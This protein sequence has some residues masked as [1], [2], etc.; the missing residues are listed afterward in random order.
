[1]LRDPKVLAELERRGRNGQ[2]AGGPDVEMQTRR[3]RNR[4]RVVLR[5]ITGRSGR[6]AL[7]RA[8]PAA[9]R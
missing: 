2:A 4:N 1:M 3:G 7:R 5:T 9:K 6:A 8:L